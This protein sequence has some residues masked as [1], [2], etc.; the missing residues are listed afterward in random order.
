MIKRIAPHHIK[1]LF[2]NKT[3]HGKFN[4]VEIITESLGDKCKFDKEHVIIFKIDDKYFRAGILENKDGE[5]SFENQCRKD[6]LPGS[7]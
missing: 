4:F 6:S 3:Q 5:L 2:D 1:H 7:Q